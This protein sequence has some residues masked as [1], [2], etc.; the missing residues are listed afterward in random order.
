MLDCVSSL[1]TAV[2]GSLRVG[3]VHNSNFAV[4]FRTDVFASLFNGKGSIF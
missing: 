1:I 4:Q 2:Q 3:T